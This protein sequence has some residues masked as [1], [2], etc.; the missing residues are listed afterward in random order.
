MLVML[1][2]LLAASGSAAFADEQDRPQKQDPTNA[3]P[4]T[5]QEEKAKDA[6]PQPKEEPAITVSLR[7]GVHFKSSDGNLDATLGGYVGIHYRVVAHR[8]QDNVRSSPDSWFIRQARPEFS[9]TV[10]KDFDFRL[11]LDFPSGNGNAVTGTL[12]DAYVGWRRYPELSF[13]IGQFKEP[14]GQEQ[15]TPDRYLDFDERSLGDRFVPARDIGA[16]VYGRLFDGIFGYEAGYFNGNGRGVV[17]S[18]KGK[19]V[20]GRV[21]VMPFAAA[22]DG[23]VLRNLRLGV[24][25]TAGTVQKSSSNGLDSTSPALGILY[26]DATA[27]TLDGARKRLGGELSWNAGPFGL[28]AEVWRRVDGID[29]GAFDNE[30]LSTTAWNASASWLITGERKPLEA[31]VAP[32]APL[33]PSAGAWGAVELAVRV[34]RVRIGNEVFGTG[35]AVAAGN[36]NAATDYTLGVNWYLTRHLRISPNV[37]WEVYEDPIAFSTGR[38]DRHFFGGILRF[39]LEF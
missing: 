25:A 8:P 18:N 26:L 6:K 35:V 2:L 19:E 36:S 21:R 28:R 20:A 38:S 15:T 13:R 34:D 29:N 14:F 33:D 37:F 1:M 31:R 11:Q 9:G 17:D 16:M 4:K 10:Y 22:G 27:G 30:R 23:F 32:D 24:A 12:Q 7:D 39:Q 3:E 5:T